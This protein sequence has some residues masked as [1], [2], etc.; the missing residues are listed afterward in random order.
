MSILLTNM[1]TRSSLHE[2]GVSILI[3]VFHVSPRIKQDLDD[4]LVSTAAGVRECSVANAGL[5]ID[6][7]SVVYQEL[8]DV[9]IATRGSLHKGGGVT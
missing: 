8:H 7:S 2:R 4:I 1:T 6:I 5:G 3:L 9:S